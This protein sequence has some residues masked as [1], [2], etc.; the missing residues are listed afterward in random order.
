VRGCNDQTKNFV[1]LHKKQPPHTNG[2]AVPTKDENPALAQS[3]QEHRALV[4]RARDEIRD[5]ISQFLKEYS[6][7]EG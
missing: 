5:Y 4:L 7:S 2:G 3:P 1:S 6:D